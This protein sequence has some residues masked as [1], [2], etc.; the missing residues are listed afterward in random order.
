[1]TIPDRLLVFFCLGMLAYLTVNFW[2]FLVRWLDQ[3]LIPDSIFSLVAKE[4]PG[5]QVY[6]PWFDLPRLGLILVWPMLII[7][8]FT[9]VIIIVGG[10]ITEKVSQHR[11]P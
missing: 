1:M 5:D 8:V 4:D 10:F 3:R 9:S 7:Y 11:S 6:F 2:I